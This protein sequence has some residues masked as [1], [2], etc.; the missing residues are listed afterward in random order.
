MAFA[1]PQ[2]ACQEER[3]KLIEEISSTYI[4]SGCKAIALSCIS[5]ASE[6]PA[7]RGLPT[8]PRCPQQLFSEIV[9]IGVSRSAKERGAKLN[10]VWRR[11][12]TFFFLL[13]SKAHIKFPRERRRADFPEVFTYVCTR[14]RWISGTETAHTTQGWVAAALKL[15]FSSLWNL[16]LYSWGPC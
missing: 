12:P 7:Q 10:C 3:I 15:Y 13:P 2:S 6:S 9:W 1:F 16:S 5:P 14:D 8:S 4:K 11:F